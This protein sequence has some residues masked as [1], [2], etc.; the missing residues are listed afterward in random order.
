MFVYVAMAIHMFSS[1]SGVLQVFQTYVASVSSIF[2]RMLQVFYPD[3]TKVDWML[4]MLQWD[5]P[6]APV[7]YNY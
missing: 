5:P 2:R 1:F 6:A 4:H 7:C 3:D